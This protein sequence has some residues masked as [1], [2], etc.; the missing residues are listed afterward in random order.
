[1]WSAQK[2]GTQEVLDGDGRPGVDCLDRLRRGS[3]EAL[4]ELLRGFWLPLA[5]YAEHLVEG[6]TDLAEDLVQ[7]AFVRLWERRASWR[8]GSAPAPILY[9]L[10]R[11]LALNDRRNRSTRSHLLRL[12]PFGARRGVTPE[13]E[14]EGRELGEAIERAV[15]AL[16]ARRRE[17]FRLAWVHGL[18]YQE[19]AGVLSI[20]PRT[21]ANQMSSALKELRTVLA[22]HLAD[23][24]GG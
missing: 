15:E 17:V 11:N 2:V 6:R 5:S 22:P 4:D 18:S 3:A 7:E 9:T 24:R 8:E 1:M 20:T 23:T 10:V 12:R 19:V 13:R 14:L 16:P 21:V